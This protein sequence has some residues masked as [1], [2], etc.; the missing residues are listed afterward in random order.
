VVSVRA[1]VPFSVRR[2]ARSSPYVTS[3]GLLSRDFRVCELFR[4]RF[5]REGM[6]RLVGPTCQASVKRLCRVRR[7]A[8]LALSARPT[9]HTTH[10]VESYRYASFASRTPKTP[11]SRKTLSCE[12]H[13]AR[14]G[15]LRQRAYLKRE[16]IRQRLVH[17]DSRDQTSQLHGRR[18]GASCDAR[19]M[20]VVKQR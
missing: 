8:A 5:R 10:E 18:H 14:E 9:G 2:I 16:E 13:D 20:R 1:Y 6:V 19:A 3:R 11:F 4:F 12:S 17:A 15:L 7:D